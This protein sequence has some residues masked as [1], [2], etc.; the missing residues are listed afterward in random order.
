MTWLG[1]TVRELTDQDIQDWQ[2][3]EL[4]KLMQIND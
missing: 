2:D 1:K 4:D 3:H